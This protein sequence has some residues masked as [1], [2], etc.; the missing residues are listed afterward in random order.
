MKPQVSIYKKEPLNILRVLSEV[1]SK[2]EQLPD[3]YYYLFLRI[4]KLITLEML[5]T[6]EAH[7]IILD[8]FKFG[9]A[10]NFVRLL[11]EV[12]LLEM[13]F[14]AVYN[15]IKVDGGHYHNETVYTHVLGALRAL[16][17]VK[18]PWEVKLS[19]LYHDVGKVKW[20]ISEEGRRRFT[21]HAVFGKSL[22]EGDLRRLNFPL[23][24]ISTPKTLVGHH[25]D[26]INDRFDIHIH[27]LRRLVRHF[28]ENHVPLKYFFWVRYAD[29]MGSAVRETDFMYY[30][31]VYKRC[32]EILNKKP[33]PSVKDLEIDGRDVMNILSL[34]E[35]GKVVGYV[36]SRLF[37]MW[38][39]GEIENNKGQL[40]PKVVRLSYEYDELQRV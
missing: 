10:Y 34:S 29:N 22:V 30:W 5:Q 4:R 31:K 21:N 11:E 28:K 39:N 3:D 14:P 15:L 37:Q 16:D 18:V 9:G 2:G 38:Q 24:T 6:E 20:E 35:G 23:G 26:H 12:E 7:K 1:A 25:M 33:D 17:K 36:L 32:L 40:F 27:S 8:P 13:I 19:A